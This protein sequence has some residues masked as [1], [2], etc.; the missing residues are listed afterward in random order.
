MV[1]RIVKQYERLAK[2]RFGTFI[3]MKGPG[4][5]IVL[6][7]MHS[8]VR[9]DLREIFFD[10]PPQ[11]NITRDNAGVDVDFVVYMRV[12]D[13]VMTV[14][15]VQDF[16][17]AA[18]QLATTT[19]RAVIGDLMLDDV[20]SRRD[21]INVAMQIKLDAVTNRWGVKVTAV[22]IREIEPP[23]A[24][25]EA[26]TRQMSA[27]RTRRAQ[28][29][30]S[31]GLRDAQINVAEGD[32]QSAVLRAEGHK[33]SEILRAEGQRQSQILEAEGF[34]Q[35]LASINEV[36]QTADPNTMG[37]Q[38]L[39]TMAKLGE[40]DSTKWIIPMELASV[41]RSIGDRLGGL[42]GGNGRGGAS[43]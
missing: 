4:I 31:E 42:G 3:G 14:L 28:I 19:L 13:P 21:D 1:F 10:V 32:R 8:A 30:E 38:Y 36:A 35:A 39:E 5:V 16:L 11:R 20:L 26:M 25:Q 40:G 23:P 34:A 27:E 24:I 43:A 37:L 22:E 41:A 7:V 33:Q 15:E 9:V 12:E 29:T 17:G 2:F 6:P 18:R